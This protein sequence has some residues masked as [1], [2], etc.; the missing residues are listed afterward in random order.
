MKNIYRTLAFGLICTMMVSCK[1]DFLAIVP[2][3]QKIAEDT[4]DY[5]K[6]MN[7]PGIAQYSFAGGWQ[8]QAIMG[9][10][11][12]AELNKFNSA[13][14]VTQ[15]AFKWESQI[16]RTQDRDW[17]TSLWLSNLYQLNKV[18]N[19]VM[20]SKGGSDQQKREILAEAQANRAWIYF[21]LINF[22][23]KPY[24]A[25][26]AST[27]PGF[28]III[29]A[30]INVDKFTRGTVQE[31]YDFIIK[32]F[33]A[34]IPY[35]PINSSSGIRFNKSAAEGLL[36]KVY[37]F[38]GNK[39]AE[40]LSMFNAAFTDNAARSQPARLYNYNVEFSA[41]GKF[42]PI[43][44]DGP[45]NSPGANNNDFTESLVS[46]SFYNAD[47]SGNGYGNDPVVLSKGASDLFTPS[48]LRLKFYAP[49]FPYGEPNPSGRLRKYAYKYVQFGLQISELY[50]LRA[51]VKA[52]LGNLAGAV[53][54][55]V[56]LRENRMPNGVN[57]PVSITSD[58]NELIKFIFEERVR[59]FAMEG[60]RWF[61]MRRE[62]IDPI[63]NG[64]S[65]THILYNYNAENNTDA[66]AATYVLKKERLTLK[67]P[68]F[69]TNTNPN[70]ENN[71]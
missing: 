56:T 38:M 23:G 51:E 40:A 66:V 57:P 9:D 18:I 3:G 70:L 37:L 65:Y 10:D 31:V 52:K 7:D 59:E 35:L 43:N 11:M 55:L 14:L 67:L 48:D 16:F 1:K 24:Q 29:T 32:E 8:G 5:S 22:Y 19:E 20:E 17:S 25:G 47:Y 69:I 15:S 68:L 44:Y 12:S 46:K 21:Q 49:E 45:S 34:A 60:Y 54:D 26:S 30:D 4:E 28:P 53:E 58:K 64:K 41:G 36:G 62:S 50:L 13:E 33:T 71:P 6:L 39:N 63:F 61:D 27:D 42:L 2:Q